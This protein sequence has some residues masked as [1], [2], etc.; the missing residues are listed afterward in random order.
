MMIN[1]LYLALSLFGLG[2]LI[3]IHELG[4]YFVAKKV[5][6]KVE[7][8]SIGFGKPI[9]SWKK[10]EESFQLCVFPFGGYVKIKGMEGNRDAEGGF[11]SVSVFKRILVALAGPIANILLAF[12]TFSLIYVLGGRRIDFSEKN[13]FIGYITREGTLYQAGVREG[14]E[15]VSVNESNVSSINDV[16]VEVVTHPQGVN[17]TYKPFDGG[18]SKTVFVKNIGFYPGSFLFFQNIPN[19]V[20]EEARYLKQAGFEKG[21]R[22]LAV[23][24]KAVFSKAALIDTLQEPHVLVHFKRNDEVM[25]TRVPKLSPSEVNLSKT[26]MGEWTDWSHAAKLKNIHFILPYDLTQNL[27][28]ESKLSY[29][30]NQANWIN[31]DE[32]LLQK[33]D[34]IIA[35]NGVSVSNGT[36]LATTLDE[37]NALLWI[38]KNPKDA[39]DAGEAQKYFLEA[40]QNPVYKSLSLDPTL[41]QTDSYLQVTVPKIRLDE[42][43]LSD[44]EKER[45]QDLIA[46]EKKQIDAIK[47]PKLKAAKLEELELN[48]KRFMIGGIFQDDVVGVQTNPFTELYRSSLMTFKTIGS[49][50]KGNLSPKQLSGPVAIVG[51]MKYGAEKSLI[52]GLYYFAIISVNLALFNLLPLPVLDGGHIMFAIYEA[53]FRRPFPQKW[54]ERLTFL[55]IILLL[56]MFVFTTYNDLFRVFKKIF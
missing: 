8:F 18:D 15:I 31:S 34:Q 46:K 39:I 26:Q 43:K 48:Q 29:L 16:Y 38:Q 23:N 20:P 22:L 45:Q 10:G 40:Y 42:L 25:T 9:K 17:L 32:S 27:E 35:I 52:E 55:F 49:L 54:A 11:Y 30:D 19:I 47:D 53:I 56:A 21:D 36:E 33:G 4:H 2:F 50:F 7:V 13:T 28:V 51:V 14:D 41:K 6:M 12:L 5:G 1:L 24:G 44:A 3:F 37:N